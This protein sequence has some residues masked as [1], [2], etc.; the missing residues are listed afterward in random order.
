MKRNHTFAGYLLVGIGA[1]FLLKQ[2]QVPILT[3]FYSWPTLLIIIGAVF[4][5]YSHTAKEHEHLFTGTLLLG[6]GIH[7]HGI[8]HYTFWPQ[9]WA[10]FPLIVGVAFLVRALKTKSGYLPGIILCLISLP[11]LLSIQLPDWFQQLYLTFDSLK[12]YWPI[13]LIAIGIY[14]LMRKK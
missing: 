12:M 2:L 5:F 4:L 3:D 8:A 6:L 7:F 14:M 9:H 11:M 13:I 10:M 1:Y